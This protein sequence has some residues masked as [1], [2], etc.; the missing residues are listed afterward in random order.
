MGSEMCIRAGPSTDAE[1]VPAVMLA[2]TVKS[3]LAV[4]SAC[5]IVDT[6]AVMVASAPKITPRNTCFFIIIVPV[7]DK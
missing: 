3:R 1:Q 4:P 7:I 2:F 6:P 5:V